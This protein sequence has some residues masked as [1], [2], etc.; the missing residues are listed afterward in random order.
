M[1]SKR[2]NP[3]VLLS[4]NKV[5]DFWQ[6]HFADD[7]RKVLYI[8]GKGFD[9][10]MNLGI[11]TLLHSSPSIS[12]KCL[13]IEFDEGK[14]SHSHAYKS[15][16]DENVLELSELLAN[17]ASEVRKMSL[18]KGVGK[19]RRRVGDRQ[20]AEIIKDYSELKNYTDI[21]IDIS[22]LPRGVYF[23]LIGKILS[24]IDTY[25]S[26][27]VP[28]LFITV[29]ENAA[30]DALI[31]EDAAD[32]DLSYLYGFGG[33]IELTSVL[34]KPLIW[35]P[36]LG[37][38]KGGHLR[39]AFGKITESKNRLFE[40]CPTLP[41]PSKDPRRSDSLLM[42]YH[43]ILFD[44]LLIE[45]QNIT[46][47]PEQNPFEVYVQLS[48]AIDNYQKSLYV[49]GGCK[50]AI[51]TFSSKLLSIGSLL[52]AYEN[53]EFIGVLNVDSDGGYKIIDENLFKELKPKSELFVSW[54]TGYPYQ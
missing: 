21:I 43:K 25:A 49:I 19:K 33:E 17:Q 5:T 27:V 14:S 35:F 11:S 51:S 34:E 23:S 22:S 37:E 30:I 45:P 3:Y 8:M 42:E 1:S 12:M 31:I 53:K 29:A 16:V 36:I 2:W 24:L 10:R 20:A 44:E 26:D 6:E 39:K 7:T 15:F 38:D 50:A 40:I 41:F 9:V 54:L 52:A 32:E 13:L 47:V 4:A 18:W 28:N 48:E 46:Y